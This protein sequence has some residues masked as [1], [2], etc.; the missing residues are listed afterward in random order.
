MCCVGL[1]QDTKEREEHYDGKSPGQHPKRMFWRERRHQRDVYGC[2]YK[3][4]RGRN[5]SESCHWVVVTWLNLFNVLVL[6]LSFSLAPDQPIKSGGPQYLACAGVGFDI[7]AL[8]CQWYHYGIHYGE[9]YLVCLS[10]WHSPFM[11]CSP[12]IPLRSLPR[13]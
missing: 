11:S 1:L 10:I 6:V 7:V 3:R 8:M 13:T 2:K 4:R 5:G 12:L 9:V